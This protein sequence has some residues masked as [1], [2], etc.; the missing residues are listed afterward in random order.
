MDRPPE[1]SSDPDAF[2]R[3]AAL[4]EP[5]RR[6]LYFYVAHA[7]RPVSRD[8]A[9]QE[10]GFRRGLVAHHLDRLADDGLLEVE[11]RRLTGRSGPGAGR[12]AKLYRVAPGRHEV[13]VPA[14]NAQLLALLL[15][16]AVV[17]G[18]RKARDSALAA[19]RE[20]GA[21]IGHSVRG[22]A[23]PTGGPA[24]L[25]NTLR[26]YGYAPVVE[27]GALVL[28]NCPFEPLAEANRDLVCGMN[29]ALIQGAADALRLDPQRCALAYAPDRCCVRIDGF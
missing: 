20:A 9:A 23:L 29:L 6:D 2:A 14:S 3:L 4:C 15:A 16:R 25:V 10:L 24:A 19:A 27:D 17:H 18:G 12:P 5:A 11:Y 26:D 22:R 28:D 13:S 21:A 7:G 8:E 1:P